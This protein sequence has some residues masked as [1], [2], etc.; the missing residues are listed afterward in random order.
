MAGAEDSARFKQLLEGARRRT[1]DAGGDTTIVT[2]HLG[3][4]TLFMLRQGLEFYPKQDSFGRRKDFINAVLKLNKVDARFESICRDHLIDGGGLWFFRPVG[5]LYRISWFRAGK[6]KTYY[7]DELSIEQCIVVYPFRVPG[8]GFM[9]VSEQQVDSA[10]NPIKGPQA[11]IRLKIFR[12]KIYEEIH[13]NEPKPEDDDILGFPQVALRSRETENS[14]GF[15]PVVEVFNELDSTDMIGHGDFNAFSHHILVHDSSATN[16]RKNLRFFGNPTLV[17]SRQKSEI[18]ESDDGAPA[19]PTIGSQSGFGSPRNPSTRVSEPAAS[20]DGGIKIPR[21]IAGLEPTDR[22]AYIQ[23]NAISSDHMRFTDA[24]KA[25]IRLALGGVDDTDIATAG[26]AYEIKSLYGRVAATAKRKMRDLFE[27]G[28]CELLE[29]MIFHEEQL[30]RESFAVAA[31]IKK[32]LAP[33]REDFD[34]DDEAFVKVQDEY[35]AANQKYLNTLESKIVEAAQEGKIPDGVVG[36]IPD[37]MRD[38]CW[39]WKGPVFEDSKEDILNASI[40]A[41]NL[42]ELGVSSLEALQTLYPDKTEEELAALLTGYPF[43]MAQAVQG[44]I[45]TFLDLIGRCM[46]IP[47]P[48]DPSKPLAA[49]Q[50]LDMTPFV[51]RALEFLQKELSYSGRYLSEDPGRDPVILSPADRLRAEQHRPLRDDAAAVRRDAGPG[52]RPGDA[53]WR[54]WSVSGRGSEPVGPER[55]WS[56][57]GAGA[58][59]GRSLDGA[60]GSS[61]GMGGPLGSAPA[62][63]PARPPDLLAP[64][65]AGGI[66]PELGSAGPAPGPVPFGRP[67]RSP[68]WAQ[69]A[70][71]QPPR[72]AGADSRRGKPPR[73]R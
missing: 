47:H 5:D 39:R 71:N 60:G 15:V 70:V 49:D 29:L 19:R 11:W 65:F 7:D 2:G 3:Q 33:L 13:A 20:V 30:F 66:P 72:P 62:G 55:V 12:D 32:P 26:T 73:P 64:T 25:E 24:Y 48:Q 43:R 37:G 53:E 67:N 61:G 27:Y 31:K 9:G 45:G 28:F 69:G 41:R 59:S 4:M 42:Q 21:I 18:V 10:G 1:G 56:L 54:G 36:L 14:L 57:P 58:L 50:N 34:G 35:N 46:Q 8:R 51:N 17:T 44:S 68:I 52:G 16:I 63:A 38:V 40:V 22:T 23:P 6:F